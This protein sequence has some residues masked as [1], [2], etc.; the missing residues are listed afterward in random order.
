V[1]S[2]LANRF[3]AKIVVGETLND[4]W[5]WTGSIDNHGYGRIQR[6]GR[7]GG[8]LRASRASWIIHFGEPPLGMEVCHECDNPI[9]SNPLHL[10]LGTHAENMADA[11]RKGRHRKRML[12]GIPNNV[13]ESNG[14]AKLSDGQIFEIRMMVST[15]IS[16]RQVADLY[17]VRQTH[18]SRI[19]RGERR[20]AF[21]Q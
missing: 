15:G 14:K 13:G 17:G 16:Q 6:G 3:L 20:A 4:C 18:I 7:D 1:R 19:I 5:S 2:S 11:A 21:T 8:I 10:F 12:I 9:C